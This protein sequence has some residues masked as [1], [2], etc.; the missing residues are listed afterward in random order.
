M[1][2][3]E[4][5]TTSSAASPPPSYSD[6][7]HPW[8]IQH[9]EEE[10]EQIKDKEEEEEEDNILPPYECTVS[11]VGHVYVKKERENQDKVAKKRSWR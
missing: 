11:R 9:M 3:M 7:S 2:T 10:V 4:E 8:A 1:T 5:S 6:P